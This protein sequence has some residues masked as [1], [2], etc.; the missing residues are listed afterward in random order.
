MIYLIYKNCNISQESHVESAWHSNHED[1]KW[2]YKTFLLSEAIDLG[3]T[4]NP[5]WYNMMNHDNHHPLLSKDEYKK[6]A[7]A[8]ERFMKFNDFKAYIERERLAVKIKYENIH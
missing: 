1:L 8:W 4:I 5:H 2:R 3:I 6:K 7:K